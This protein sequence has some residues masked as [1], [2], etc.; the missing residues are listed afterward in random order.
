MNDLIK[1]IEFANKES[2]KRQLEFLLNKIPE[3]G[4]FD[5]LLPS[6]YMFLIKVYIG[7]ILELYENEPMEPIKQAAERRIQTVLKNKHIYLDDFYKMDKNTALQ[8]TRDVAK[9]FIAVYKNK[10]EDQIG[11]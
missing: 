7:K 11:I 4:G 2:S 1:Y 8:D 9:Y 10:K 6:Q 3:R 5:S